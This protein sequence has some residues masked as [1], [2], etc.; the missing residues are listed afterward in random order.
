M[1]TF[2]VAAAMSLG[3]AAP[4]IADPV[5]GTWKTQVDDGHYAHIKMSKCDGGKICGVIAKAFDSSGEI[6]TPNVGKRLVWGMQAKGGGS[7]KN[8]TIWQPSTGKEYKSKMKLAG[9]KLKVE[10]CV[11]IICKEQTWT[12]VK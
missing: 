12:R 7:Y 4:A 6:T 2:V 1:K 3:L 8:G 5:L 9:S 11:L 10:G